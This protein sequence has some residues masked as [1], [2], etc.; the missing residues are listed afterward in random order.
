[1]LPAYNA[2]HTLQATVDE[3]PAIVDHRILVD[4]GSS[5]ETVGLARSCDR[6]VSVVNS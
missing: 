4:D 3:L 2:A 6:P 5:D 1:V